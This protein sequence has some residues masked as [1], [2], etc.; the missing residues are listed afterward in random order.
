[1]VEVQW[2]PLLLH[3][4]HNSRLRDVLE[5]HL[6]VGNNDHRRV[7]K[8]DA[9]SEKVEVVEVSPLVPLEHQISK[10]ALHSLVYWHDLTLV[11]DCNTK[12]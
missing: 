2:A 10:M 5:S 8:M 1:M 4:A 7:G 9:A 6:H 11:I 3:N 12:K